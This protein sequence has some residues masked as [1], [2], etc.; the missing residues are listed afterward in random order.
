MHFI[1]FTSPPQQPRLL[2]ME[3]TNPLHAL[4]DH[5]VTLYMPASRSGNPGEINDWLPLPEAPLPPIRAAPKTFLLPVAN[6]ASDIGGV[7]F[8]CGNCGLSYRLTWNTPCMAVHSEGCHV[9]LCY[10]CTYR[11]KDPLSG[12]SYCDSHLNSLVRSFSRNH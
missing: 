10:N 6:S 2:L 11:N 7:G 3:P 9:V 4:A 5:A 1:C 8:Q 12:L